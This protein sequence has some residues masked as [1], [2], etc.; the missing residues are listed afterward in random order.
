MKRLLIALWLAT[1]VAACG[2][3]ALL[4]K[5]ESGDPA[6]ANALGERYE[7]GKDAEGNDVRP[8]LS[9]AVKWYHVAAAKGYAPAQFNI[10]RDKANEAETHRPAA[11]A[12][13]STAKKYFNDYYAAAAEWYGKAADQGHGD[14]QHELAVI[15][16]GRGVKQDLAVAKGLARKAAAQGNEGS[17]KLLV[18][19]DKGE[20]PDEAGAAAKAIQER[21]K[22]IPY[23][24]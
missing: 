19:I 16:Y 3:D 10:G 2:D 6:A 11:K 22:L 14:A 13:V 18:A 17:K 7:A 15:Y 9:T 5:A 21:Q 24:Q 1:F 12:G 8:D 23:Q 20:I 4:D